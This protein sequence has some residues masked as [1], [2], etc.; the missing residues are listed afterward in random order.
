[1]AKEHVINAMPVATV[2]VNFAKESGDAIIYFA[3]TS[4]ASN[5]WSA[6]LVALDGVLYKSDMKAW[7]GKITNSSAAGLSNYSGADLVKALQQRLWSGL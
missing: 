2:V 7:N 4:T 1:M 5:D 3:S 6:Y